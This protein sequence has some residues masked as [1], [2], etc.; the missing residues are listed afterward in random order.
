MTDKYRRNVGIIVAKEGK[1][2]LCARADQKHMAWQFPQGGIEDG[3]EI[4]AAARRELQEETALK[5]LELIA[6]MPQALRYDFPS[7][8]A[9]LKAS[10]Y[11]GQEQYWVLFRFAGQD[12]EIDFCTNPQEI[13]F[14]AFEWTD[15][16]EA[17]K[18]I[19]P[20]KQAVYQQV[21]DYFAPYL[22][23]ENND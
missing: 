8:S 7:G 1:V 18:R 10:T 12:S 15:I 2:L 20:F 6:V 4:V 22:Q 13:E 9:W 21:V 5:D 3:E 19:I 17:P 14:K 16:F 11:K 23:G